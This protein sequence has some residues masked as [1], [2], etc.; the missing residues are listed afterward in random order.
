[1][2]WYGY[3]GLDWEIFLYDGT[4]ITQ[5]TN[6]SYN[7]GAPQ[8]NNNR[9]VVWYGFDGSDHEIFLALSMCGNG[10]IDPGEQCDDGNTNN[11]DGCPNNCIVPVCGDG[12][13]APGETCDPPGQPGSNQQQPGICRQSCTYCIDGVRITASN[14]T[15]AMG[16]TTVAL[17]TARA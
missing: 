15:M 16:S 8:I 9:Y 12:I 3:D 5:L 14:A 1:V 2:V 13:I 7:D 4:G 11:Y 17:I 6:N 10:I